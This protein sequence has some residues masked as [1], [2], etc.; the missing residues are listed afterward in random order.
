MNFIF[1]G[2]GYIYEQSIAEDTILLS[3]MEINLK[4]KDKYFDNNL[5]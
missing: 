4:L 5:G 3:D 1:E 2:Y